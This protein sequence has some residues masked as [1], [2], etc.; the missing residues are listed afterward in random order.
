MGFFQIHVLEMEIK[1]LSSSHTLAYPEVLPW[2]LQSH[3]N[4]LSGKK[5]NQPTKQANRKTPHQHQ[6]LGYASYLTNWTNRDKTTFPLNPDL[7]TKGEALY[8][9]WRG[10]PGDHTFRLHQ[11]PHKS[12]VLWLRCSK[13]CIR[14]VRIKL[15]QDISHSA[16]ATIDNLFSFSSGNFYLVFVL[17]LVQKGLIGTPGHLH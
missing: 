11:M 14:K 8:I 2:L 12:P 5:Q 15:A 6:Q 7:N 4:A 1:V 13:V 3:I 10:E 16:D 9:T 17:C